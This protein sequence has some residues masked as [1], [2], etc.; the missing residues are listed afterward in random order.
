MR[1]E[2]GQSVV[3]V[4]LT[5]PLVFALLIVLLQFGRAIYTWIALTHLANEGARYAAVNAFPSGA[6]SP[7]GFV[8]QTLSKDGAATNKS[9]TV[10]FTSGTPAAGDG[11]TVNVAEKYKIIPFATFW[12]P[13]TIGIS[14]NSTMR[15]EQTPSYSS[16]STSC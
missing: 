1:S 12:K 10:S 3:E 16:G 9:V 5:L 2:R 14:V 11:V 4:A 13:V 15:L 8:C 7:G 6:T